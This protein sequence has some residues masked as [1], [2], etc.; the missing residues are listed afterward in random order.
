M[1]LDDLLDDGKAETDASWAA[2]AGRIEAHE[3]LD[4][5]RKLF[6]RNAGPVIDDVDGD[7]AA[8]ARRFDQDGGTEV[9]SVVDE[10]G[11]GSGD[12]IGPAEEA[13]LVGAFI[14][15]GGAAFLVLVAE[16]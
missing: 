9:N 3:R 2:G 6:S 7:A 11:Y 4:D 12:R 5:I 14:A 8:F 16:R 15:D 13:N 10:V 1:R